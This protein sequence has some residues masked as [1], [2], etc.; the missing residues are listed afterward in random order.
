MVRGHHYADADSGDRGRGRYSDIL[1]LR[2]A[3]EDMVEDPVF[4]WEV[5]WSGLSLV[6]GQGQGKSDDDEVELT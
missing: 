5:I 2:F 3:G 4:R 6:R 1:I